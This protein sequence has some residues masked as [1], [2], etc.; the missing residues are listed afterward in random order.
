MNVDL[1]SKVSIFTFNPLGYNYL[2]LSASICGFQ[3]FFGCGS[4]A[5][6]NLRMFLS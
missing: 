4:A 2:R 6:G 5:L 3:F 1:S